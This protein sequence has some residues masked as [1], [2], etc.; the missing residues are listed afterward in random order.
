[1]RWNG[2]GYADRGPALSPARQRFVVS[3]LATRMGVAPKATVPLALAQLDLPHSRADAALLA[4]L[5]AIVGEHDVRSSD[6]ERVQ[7]ATGKSLPDVIRLRS[8]EITRA[9]DAVVYPRSAAQVAAL[10]ALAAEQEL[11]VVPFG[12]G[13]SVVGGVDPHLPAG[14][15]ALIALDT[16]GLDRMLAFDATSGTAS[17]EAG[18]DGPALEA[19]LGQNAATLGHF[20]QSF[21]H[22]TLGGWIATRSSGQQSDGY[23]GIEQ[24]LV[25]ARMVTP[26]GELTSL[27]VPRQAAGP[28]LRELML[29]SEGTLGVIVEATVRVHPRPAVQ[30][31]HGVLFRDFAAGVSALRALLDAQLPLSMLRLS[32]AEETALSLLLR[33]DPERRFDAG[34]AVLGAA[35][36]A[37]YADGRCLLLLC[38]EGQEPARAGA[39]LLHA[40]RLCA[41]RGGLPLGPAPGR[42][43]LRDRFS[44]PYLRDFLLDH[45]FAIDTLETAFE[46]RDL[47]RGHAR[48]VEALRDAARDHAGGGLAMGHV[49]HSYHDGACVY[50]IVIYPIAQAAPLV[51]WQAI[52]R[53]ATDAIVR[54]GGTLSHHHGVGRDHLPWMAQEKGELGLLALRAVKQAL[55]PAGVMN[56][57]KLL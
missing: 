47:Q 11:C 41:Q 13:T 16:T 30:H 40:T 53:A 39:Q 24:L 45:G 29:G 46:W 1:L 25:S 26:R 2:W 49:S 57:G 14:K 51:Q 19:A 37:G 52:K 42:S 4:Q 43:W 31:V 5:T 3:A 8:G 20:P 38:L 7:H 35:R 22:S 36:G 23:G 54:C 12:G 48:V 15:R 9:P 33:H 34:A 56:P 28:D 6:L 32:D 50:F 27:C 44:N 10:L 18:V 55:D 21:E 17:F